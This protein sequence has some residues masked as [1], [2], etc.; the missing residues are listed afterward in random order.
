MKRA[1]MF[2]ALSIVTVAVG[3]IVISYIPG[4]STMIASLSK[5]AA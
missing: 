5:R 3:M 1:F 2:V 4:A